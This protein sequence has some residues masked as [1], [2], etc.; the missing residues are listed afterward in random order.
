MRGSKH[1]L[2]KA[3][4]PILPVEA[5]A[6]NLRLMLALMRALILTRI[7]QDTLK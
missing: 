1:C 6:T 5:A 4:K 3:G 2:E 7:N